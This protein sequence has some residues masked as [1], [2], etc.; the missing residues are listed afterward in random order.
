MKII[1][2]G[3]GKPRV[4]ER[5]LD[6]D[7]IVQ[8]TKEEMETIARYA[9]FSWD[10][11]GEDHNRDYSLASIVSITYYLK[12]MEAGENA[13]IN[14]LRAMAL[15]VEEHSVTPPRTPKVT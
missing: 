6:P 11:S 9:G 12:R 4:N 3:P 13:Y 15:Y 14:A 2:R 7:Y 8:M 1:G 10:Y 5:T